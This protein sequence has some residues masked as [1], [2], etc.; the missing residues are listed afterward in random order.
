[1]NKS[2]KI[3]VTEPINFR[4]NVEMINN[5]KKVARHVSY[6]LDGE[7]TYVDVI[8]CLLAEYFSIPKS[9]V[10]SLAQLEYAKEMCSKIDKSAAIS[11]LT[12]MPVTFT[13]SS[14]GM[15]VTY[16]Y[17]QNDTSATKDN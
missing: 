16:V 7:Y 13:T 9:E 4:L 5:L 15:N 2:V 17:P 1:M 8:R 10:E 3:S 12:Q 6:H 11:G 14:G